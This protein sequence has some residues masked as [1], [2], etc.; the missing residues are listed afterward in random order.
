MANN[1]PSIA[2]G[3]SFSLPSWAQHIATGTDG[4]TFS[5]DVEK[6]GWVLELGHRN[7]QDGGGPFAAAIFNM[8]S[9]VLIAP[10]LNRVMPC[11]CSVLHAEICAIILAQQQLGRY[12]LAPEIDEDT[13]GGYELITSTE[14][15]AMCLGAVPWAGIKRLVCAARDEDARAVG[16]DEGDKPENW[17]EKLEQRGVQVQRDTCRP[18]AVDLLQDYLNI[19]GEIYN[20]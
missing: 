8:D 11:N 14:P 10:G 5:S 6:M 20:G 13:K 7:I 19:N 9:G 16:F 3:F 1:S 2:A 17:V 12:T 15:C 18:A 4:R